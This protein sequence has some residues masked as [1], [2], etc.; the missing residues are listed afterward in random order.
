MN[1]E[2]LSTI[3]ILSS[4]IVLITVVLCL[5]AD[6]EIK[7]LNNEV[8]QT[9]L[10]K[11]TLLASRFELR[12]QH[13]SGALELAA[14][15]TSIASPP[16]D[17][18]LIS[19]KLKG[20]PEDADIEK[21]KIAKILLDKNSDLDY[22]FYAMP[23]GDIYFLEPFNSQIKLSQSNFSFRDWYHG[24]ITTGS[25]YVSEV[26]VSANEK[27]NVI[28]IGVP[29]YSDVEPTMLNG[30]FVGA[31]DLGELQKSLTMSS[32]GQNEYF[33]IIDHNNNIVADSRNLN[34]D[35][36]IRKFNA[37][38][39][40]S[41]PDTN[42]HIITK[43]ID[44]KDMVVTFKT[45]R[46]GTHEWLFVSVQPYDDAFAQSTL[47]RNEATLII[48]ALVV[49]VTLLGFFLIRKINANVILASELQ[50]IDVEKEQFAAMV[51][52]ELK[53]PL[54]PVIGYCKMLRTSMLGKLTDEQTNALDVIEKNAKRLER[55]ISDIMDVRKLDLN[56]IKFSMADVSIDEFFDDLNTTYTQVLSQSG[57]EFIIDVQRKGLRMQTDRNRLRQ[58]FDNLISNAIK[59]T[60]TTGAKI[61]IGCGADDG[62]LTFSVRDNGIG[63]SEDAQKFLFKKFYQID[64]SERRNVGGSGLGLA[65]CKGIVE[66]LGGKIWVESDGKTG[67][68]FYMTFKY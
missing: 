18:D 11:I 49:I 2:I 55:L 14:Q 61:T 67:S 48:I 8:T 62:K 24:V 35:V 58:C 57:K 13:L 52:H 19:E 22:V 15:T 10:N 59:F 65:I 16:V 63:I 37:H 46:A 39:D 21:R 27:H 45:V 7:R 28:G 23:N 42:A 56:R 1:K 68:T 64:T 51:T 36:E 32:L 47:L 43:T 60:P 44:E 41:T 4:V 53:T 34:S 17:S 12:L 40:I 29:I 66:C 9:Q 54:V 33:V 3:V 30:I 5:Y 6:S 26:Y 25:T 31:L 38:S 50:H 20:I